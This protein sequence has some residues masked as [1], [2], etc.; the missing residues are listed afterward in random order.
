MP[1]AS[2][3]PSRTSSPASQTIP[4]KPPLEICRRRR[5]RPPHRRRMGPPPPIISQTPSASTRAVLTFPEPRRIR[6]K[7]HLKFVATQPCLVCGRQPCDAHHLRFAQH[8]ALGRKV[9]DEF[10]VPLCRGHHREVHRCSNERA[11]WLSWNIDPAI[12]ALKLWRITRGLQEPTAK[13][14]TP[15]SSPTARRSAGAED[16]SLSDVTITSTKPEIGHPRV[17][18]GAEPH[19]AKRHALTTVDQGQR[20]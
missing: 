11:W 10:T 5:T 14:L 2:R 17:T 18:A 3:R 1:S 6:D 19:A 8:P 12:V 7:E 15:T 4:E 16:D 20:K 9:S 13:E